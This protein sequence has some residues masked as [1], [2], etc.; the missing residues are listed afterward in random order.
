VSVLILVPDQVGV[1]VN[2]MIRN[3]VQNLGLIV[4]EHAGLNAQEGNM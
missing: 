4:P 1:C 3:R 2:L